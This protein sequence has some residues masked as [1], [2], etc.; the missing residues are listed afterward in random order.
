[1]QIPVDLQ[2]SLLVDVAGLFGR[3]QQ[4]HRDAEHTMVVRPHQTL[5]GVLIALLGGPDQACFI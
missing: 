1:M 4:V 5:K 3:A 2:K